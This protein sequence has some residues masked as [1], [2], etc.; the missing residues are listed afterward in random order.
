M[1]RER[2]WRQ[3]LRTLAR[4]P[5]LQT[6][7]RATSPGGGFNKMPRGFWKVSAPAEM[8]ACAMS[9]GAPPQILW[10]LIFLPLVALLALLR[11][12]LGTRFRIPL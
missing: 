6:E 2:L 12:S 10:L 4:V 11:A 3:K 9:A 5:A 8:D 7:V 1:G